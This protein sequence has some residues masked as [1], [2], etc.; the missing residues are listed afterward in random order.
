MRQEENWEGE[1][2]KGK[3][4]SLN[5]KWFEGPT[6]AGCVL[7]SSC[8][9]TIRS[10]FR[11]QGSPLQ[12][13]TR[14]VSANLL[15]CRGSQCCHTLMEYW[16]YV[17]EANNKFG[18]L[19][20]VLQ[21]VHPSSFYEPGKK[22]PPVLVELEVDEMH[23]YLPPRPFAKECFARGYYETYLC[24]AIAYHCMVIVFVIPWSLR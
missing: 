1:A 18:L 14:F 15:L 22:K 20:F 4:A 21:K 12:Q 2:S 7:S 23:L 8:D 19:A 5:L 10:R 3:C 16:L 13:I 6:S 17:I 9:C 11:K 24:F